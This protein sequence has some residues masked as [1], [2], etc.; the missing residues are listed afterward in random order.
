MTGEDLDALVE[1]IAPVMRD[2]LAAVTQ[3][4]STLERDLA[5]I[6]AKPH[7]R[8]CGVW[9]A[10][11]PNIPGDAVTHA[12]G[13]W[14]CRALLPGKPNDDFD[15]WQLAVKRGAAGWRSPSSACAC[16]WPAPPT[17]VLTR[18]AT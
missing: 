3:R 15:G 16:S 14:I 6:T 11:D 17:M 18:P 1:G 9:K 7:L 13:L 4:V 12:G 2:A 5:A 10:D 8:F